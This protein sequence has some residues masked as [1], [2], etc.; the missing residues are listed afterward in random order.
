MKEKLTL[1]INKKT[2]EKAKQFAKRKGVSIS[3]IVETYLESI[4]GE[5]TELLHQFGKQPVDTGVNDAAENH[6]KYVYSPEK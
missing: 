1:S 5:G 4:S 6:D 2:K 3:K